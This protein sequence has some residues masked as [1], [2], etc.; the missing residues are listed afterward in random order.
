MFIRVL[1]IHTLTDEY[2]H[3]PCCWLHCKDTIHSISLYPPQPLSPISFKSVTGP[4]Q[5]HILK[6]TNWQ[7]VGISPFTRISL[8]PI[9]TGRWPAGMMSP[10][11]RH[12]LNPGNFGN[13]GSL[14]FLPTCGFVVC[15]NYC[16]ERCLC[17]TM[18]NFLVDQTDSVWIVIEF[19]VLP[20]SRLTKWYNMNYFCWSKLDEVLFFNHF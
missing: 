16:S 15:M 12:N 20:W 18:L 3:L 11:L 1:R 4:V 2:M 9:L 5:T 10:Q 8:L 19:R 7:L 13:L 6:V 14:H 17:F